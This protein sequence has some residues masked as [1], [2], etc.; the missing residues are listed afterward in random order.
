MEA[1]SYWQLQLMIESLFKKLS[2]EHR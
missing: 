1:V 2:S